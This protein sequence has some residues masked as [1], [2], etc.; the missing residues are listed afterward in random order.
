[1]S[2]FHPKLTL[3]TPRL[4]QRSIREGNMGPKFQIVLGALLTLNAI[5]EIQRGSH[6]WA[7]LEFTAAAACGLRAYKLWKDRRV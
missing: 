2:V 5:R 7:V 3:G 6:V 1:M 4:R